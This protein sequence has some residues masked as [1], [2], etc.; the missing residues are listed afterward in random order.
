MSSQPRTR[1][2]LAA[3]AAAI[4][5]L[6]GT[7]FAAASAPQ[8]PGILTRRAYLPVL[9]GGGAVA[10]TPTPTPTRTP[11]P[12]GPTATRTATPTLTRTATPTRTPTATPTHPPTVTTVRIVNS[13]MYPLV[14]LT[15]DGQVVIATES[16]A[17]PSN[18]YIDVTLSAG[19]HSYDIINGFWNQNVNPHQRIEYYEWQGTWPQPAGQLYTLTVTDPPI[20]TILSHWGTSADWAAWPCNNGGHC[21][22]CF[23]NTGNF[24]F[25]FEPMAGYGP[26]AWNT[27]G[28]Y[29]L[30]HRGSALTYFRLYPAGGP[31]GTTSYTGFF[32]EAAPAQISISGPTSAYSTNYNWQSTATCPPWAGA[33]APVPA[34][35]PGAR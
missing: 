13:T 28:T 2:L 27:K 5:L 29:A 17:L 1:I 19:Q 12:G 15:I 33:A 18:Y 20:E 11:I 8:L 31:N 26:P 10:K 24:Y 30:D 25:W 22:Y 4:V 23:Y 14:Y 34:A 21:V 6:A 16:Q 3:L 32:T 7:A 9:I 35:A